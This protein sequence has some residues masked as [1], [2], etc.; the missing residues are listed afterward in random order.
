MSRAERIERILRRREE[1]AQELAAV[2]HVAA[3]LDQ[4][5]VRLETARVA[6]T[7]KVDDDARAELDL[8]A[9]GIADLRRGVAAVRRDVGRTDARFRRPTLTIGAVGR[10]GQGKS[11]FLQTLTG[12]TSQEIPAARG[13]FMTGVPSLIRHGGGST[14]AEVEFHDEASFLEDLVRPYYAAL[15]LGSPPAS[16]DAF[17]DDA[18]PELPEGSRTTRDVSAHEHLRNY[19]EHLQ[20]YRGYL[21]GSVRVQPIKPAEII[22]FVAQHDGQGHA[23]HD[24]RAVRRVRITAP[25]GA[26]DLGKLAVVDLP[27]LGDTN[28]RDEHLLRQAIDGEVDIVLFVRRPD[29]FRD[30]VHDTDIDLYDIARNALPELALDRWSFLLLNV[31]RSEDGDNA[32]MVEQFPAM[33][34]RSPMRVVDIIAANCTDATEVAAAFDRVVD[35]A[36]AVVDELDG[37]LLQ[38]RR[39]ELAVLLAEAQ[40]L[41]TDARALSARAAPQGAWFP[42]FL[43]LFNVAHRALAR[44]L[45]RLV[46][47]FQED[48]TATDEELMEQIRQAVQVAR[49]EIVA[50]TIA[51]IDDRRDEAG[52]YS[53]ALADL[54][55]ETRARVSRQFLALDVA[56]KARVDAMHRAVAEVLR[57]SGRL[58]TL[59]PQEGREFLQMLAEQVPAASGELSYGL[60]FVADFTLNYR[61]FIQHRVRRSLRNFAPDTIQFR[62]DA[63]PGD[64]QYILEELIA[65]TLSDIEYELERMAHEPYE[66]VF[67]VAEEFRDRV[68]RSEG[69]QDE[70]RALYESL[71]SEVWADEF[72]ALAANT[73]L[74]NHW[75]QAVAAVAAVAETAV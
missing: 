55:D 16:L 70:W 20:A 3:G 51:E 37:S 9:A 60:R 62:T 44:S 50:P 58:G 2:E 5:L 43:D 17:R 34:R 52:S 57:D 49:E 33:V 31:V 74:F 46:R 32:A 30:D 27:G 53:A 36:V 65:E 73:A 28:L 47:E 72:E 67:A 15:G 56:L 48:A 69:A 10:S 26:D 63:G 19:R 64:I 45:E 11:R 1:R 59:G 18:F 66:A 13:G 7:A 4:A 8:V 29:P 6:L 21:D 39:Q 40:R 22:R 14:S 38:R 61:G 42:R 23:I 71:R 41:V 24:F 25:F 35:H 12:L 75:N 68:L 54:V